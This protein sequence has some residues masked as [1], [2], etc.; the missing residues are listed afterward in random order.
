M[1]QP[2]G[3][4]TPADAPRFARDGSGEAGISQRTEARRPARPVP[5]HRK[6]TD[7]ESGHAMSGHFV[8]MTFFLPCPRP[9][10]ISPGATCLQ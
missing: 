2:R 7:Q 4:E 6:I 8:S 1:G 3:E 9:V 5:L 10:L